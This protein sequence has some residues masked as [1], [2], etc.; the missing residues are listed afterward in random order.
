MNTPKHGSVVQWKD[1][2]GSHW[3]VV[4][5]LPEHDPGVCRVARN[6]KPDTPG[7]WI[8]NRQILAIIP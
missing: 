3:G 2:G 7:F 6:D 4:T 5:D 8:S 1:A